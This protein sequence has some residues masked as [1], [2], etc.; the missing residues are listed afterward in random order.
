MRLSSSLVVWALC[1][2]AATGEPLTANQ[3][4]MVGGWTAPGVSG[5]KRIFLARVM[6]DGACLRYADGS[7]I[8]L[9][10]HLVASKPAMWGVHR[11]EPGLYALA[12]VGWGAGEAIFPSTTWSGVSRQHGSVWTVELRLG[13]VTDIGVWT[14]VSPYAQRYSIEGAELE[15][16]RA[17][18]GA[19]A[20][21]VGPMLIAKPVKR[22]VLDPGVPCQG[23][24]GAP[25]DIGRGP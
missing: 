3:S 18:A 19:L 20:D 22:E 2:G 16:D 10:D 14:V 9:N 11:A 6:Q 5:V 7:A 12:G 13:A 1:A 15:R 4:A 17:L 8:R 24:A 23:K 25:A 21:G